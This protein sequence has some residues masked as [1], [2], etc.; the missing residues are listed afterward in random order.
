[1]KPSRFVAVAGL[2]L[3]VAAAQAAPQLRFN[4]RL[5]L[6][7]PQAV[8]F[9][10]GGTLFVP[11]RETVSQSNVVLDV[12]DRGRRFEMIYNRSTAEYV[13]GATRF[14]LNGSWRSLSASSRER[15]TILFVP[16][17]IFSQLTGGDLKID[18]GNNNGGFGENDTED[19]GTDLY[20]NGRRL[21]FSDNE[22]PYRSQ[23][24]TL[25]PF[26]ALGS[27]LSLRTDRSPDGKRVWIW[28]NSDRIEYN[29]GMVWY[30]LN[31]DRRDLSAKSEEKSG[32]LFVPIELFKALVGR[33]LSTR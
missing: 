33:N 22:Q 17:A 12:Q 26:R 15:N 7:T 4:G 29:K 18:R 9:N 25:V 11:L 28:R 8:P 20:Y 30:R 14:R 21:T 3:A 2:V 19:S 16:F 6:F 1:M 13:K 24:T 10:V 27:A 23:G 5:L 31:E 32:V